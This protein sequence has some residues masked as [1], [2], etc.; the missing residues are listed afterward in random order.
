[1]PRPSITY[2]SM[3]AI[4][5]ILMRRREIVSAE[6]STLFGLIASMNW[7]TWPYHRKTIMKLTGQRRS[8]KAPML[9]PSAP[10]QRFRIV[11][12]SQSRGF[13]QTRRWVIRPPQQPQAPNRFPAPAPRNNQPQQ[14]QQREWKQMLHMWQCGPLC[15]ELPKESAEATASTKSR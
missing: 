12:N 10:T 4:T 3:W 13:Q 6:V 9:G 7:S 11:S 1:M 15:Q 5:Q 2:A 14:Q 8:K